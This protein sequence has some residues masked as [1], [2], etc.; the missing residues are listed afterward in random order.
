MSE[1]APSVGN[2]AAWLQNE[3]R[4]IRSGFS[5]KGPKYFQRPLVLGAMMVF[6]GHFFV[7]KKGVANKSAAQQALAASQAT[8]EFAEEYRRLKAELEGLS[9]KLP[10]TSS[11]ETWLLDAVRRTLREEQI[12]P[13]ETSPPVQASSRGFRFI[14]LTVAFRAKYAQAASWVS[15]LEHGGELLFVR[16]LEVRKDGQEIGQNLVSATVT[17]MVPSQ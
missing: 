9:T 3:L 1:G 12:V 11:P 13:L 17:T 2:I 16:K 15:R 6:C 5:E 4:I 8:N 7:Y 10:R 14:S